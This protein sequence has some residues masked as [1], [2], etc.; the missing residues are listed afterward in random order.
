M[1]HNCGLRSPL[2]RLLKDGHEVSGNGQTL[3]QL[4]IAT[5][6]ALAVLLLEMIGGIFSHSLALLSD[7][8]HILA[9]VFALGMSWFALRLAKRPA[10]ANATFG[11]HRV[12][13]LVALINGVSLIAIAALIVRE[14]YTRVIFPVEVNTVQLLIVASL[15][16]T[17]N[18]GMVGLLHKGHRMVSVT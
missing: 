9:D 5:A 15:G 14:A 16:L 18:L 17:A 4:G 8:G 6:I 2:V 10:N 13:I 1:M 7:A 11:Y 3:R 12:G